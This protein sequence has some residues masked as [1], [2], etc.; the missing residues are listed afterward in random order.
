MSGP[1]GAYP[2]V[3]GATADSFLHGARWSGLS[4][5]VWGNR[6]NPADW[7]A[8]Q[9]PIP[10][11]VGQPLLHISPLNERAAYPHVC[12]ATRRAGVAMDLVKGLSPRVWGNQTKEGR[13]HGKRRPIPTCVGQPG[14][15]RA[16]H[17]QGKAYPHVCG[18]TTLQ[19]IPIRS[20]LGLSPRV[21]GN[22][23]QPHRAAHMTRPI[24]TCVGQPGCVSNSREY[25]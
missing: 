12:G 15:H 10:T 24:P 1:A 8:V 6:T 19:S 9:G 25:A 18:A 20:P 16:G 17:P 22:L 3:C 7:S 13:E 11:C 2:H 5:R 14:C 23:T 21:W 4:P